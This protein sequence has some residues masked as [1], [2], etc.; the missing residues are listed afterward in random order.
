[1]TPA[2]I[3]GEMGHLEMLDSYKE[4]PKLRRAFE[5]GWNDAAAWCAEKEQV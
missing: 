5:Q 2:G 1:M 3:Y 4:D